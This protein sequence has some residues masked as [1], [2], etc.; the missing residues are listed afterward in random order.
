MGAAVAPLSSPATSAADCCDVCGA[1]PTR[2]ARAVLAWRCADHVPPDWCS[3]LPPFLAWAEAE[4]AL[5][6][7]AEFCEVCSSYLCGHPGEAALATARP[8]TAPAVESPGGRPVDL[9]VG[10]TVQTAGRAASEPGDWYRGTGVLDG[11]PEIPRSCWYC[12]ERH[13]WLGYDAFKAFYCPRHKPLSELERLEW[14]RSLGEI[15]PRSGES[16][17]DR[18]LFG[19]ND[20]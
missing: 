20:G 11:W 19:E 10:P 18:T 5:R 4:H 14:L 16:A 17:P 15:A 1:R 7:D 6:A 8:S 13:G 3:A 2:W 9:T 12:H